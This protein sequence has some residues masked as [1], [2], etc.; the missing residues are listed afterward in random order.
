MIIG[1]FL[2][3]THKCQETGGCLVDLEFI[4]LYLDK[5]KLYNNYISLNY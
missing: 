3:Y 1:R 5:G 4:C 2:N